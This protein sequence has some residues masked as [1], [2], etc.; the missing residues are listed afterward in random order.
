M[1][2]SPKKGKTLAWSISTTSAS[3]EQKLW[4]RRKQTPRLQ[5]VERPRLMC[6]RMRYD[7]AAQAWML[8]AQAQ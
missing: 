1:E 4:R 7:L 3:A 5:V 2:V 6:G 8:T